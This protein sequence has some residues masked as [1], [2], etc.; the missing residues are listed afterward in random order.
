MVQATSLPVTV[1]QSANTQKEAQSKL[2]ELG[3]VRKLLQGNTVKQV[4]MV[5]VEVLSHSS[6]D[7]EARAE[8]ERPLVRLEHITDSNGYGFMQAES[9]QEAARMMLAL[10]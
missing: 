5:N 7:D 6:L 2:F 8:A 10:Y 1:K 3:E 9:P 4:L